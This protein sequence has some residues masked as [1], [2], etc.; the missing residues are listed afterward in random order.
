MSCCI[1]DDGGAPLL[2]GISPPSGAADATGGGT[3]ESAA[4]SAGVSVV[5]CGPEILKTQTSFDWRIESLQ[6]SMSLIF[7][8]YSYLTWLC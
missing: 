4:S 5:S 7:F 8:Q 2:G 1:S 3:G 6:S